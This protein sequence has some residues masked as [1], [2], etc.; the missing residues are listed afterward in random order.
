[1]AKGGLRLE[2]RGLNLSLRSPPPT[3]TSPPPT[4]APLGKQPLFSH[5]PVLDS[6][7]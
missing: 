7:R 2:E 3:P 6:R 1:M 5:G 4:P